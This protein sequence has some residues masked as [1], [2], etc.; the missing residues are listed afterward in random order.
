MIFS[1]AELISFI[2][3]DTTLLPGTVI[4]TGTPGGVGFVR[5]PP[6]FLKAGDVVSVTIERLGELTCPVTSGA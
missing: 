3:Q 5:K 4:L 2:S 6:V 1:V